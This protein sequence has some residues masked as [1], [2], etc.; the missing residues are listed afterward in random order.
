M[1]DGADEGVE[2][3]FKRF[4][5]VTERSGNLRKDLKKK[6]LEAVSSLRH[7][8]AQVQ[9]NLEAKT[10]TNK[11]LEMEVKACKKKYRGCETT[12]VAVRDGWCHVRTQCGVKRT[13]CD[14]C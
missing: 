1:A 2:G 9:T 12:R 10:A 13:V 6:I 3:S 7:Y 5:S 4:V 11:D 14:R 8:F